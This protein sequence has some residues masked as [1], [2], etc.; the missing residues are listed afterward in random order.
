VCGSVYHV[1]GN[2]P[3]V[4]GLCDKDQTPLMQ[5]ADDKEDVVR[6]RMRTYTQK[7]QPLI[8][9][10]KQKGLLVTVDANG[11]PDEVYGRLGKAL[12]P[13]KTS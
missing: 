3:K 2:P 12:A 6:E 13:V 9:Y 5:R 4:A 10:Y 1:T 7:T 8:D 11:S